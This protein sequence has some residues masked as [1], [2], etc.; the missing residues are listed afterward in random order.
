[1]MA[2]RFSVVS[3]ASTLASL[4][5]ISEIFTASFTCMRLSPRRDHCNA[6]FIASSVDRPFAAARCRMSATSSCVLPPTFRNT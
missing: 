3:A 4:A 2:C 6:E 5:A 1:M